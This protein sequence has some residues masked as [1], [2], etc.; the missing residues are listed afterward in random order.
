MAEVKPEIKSESPRKAGDMA[1]FE[2]DTDLQIP[3]GNRVAWL[4]KVSEDMWRAWAKMYAD[5]PE[6]Q[7]LEVGKM[8]VFHPL[9]GDAPDHTR[10]QI[11][12][13]DSR[14]EHRL[15]PKTYNLEV[16]SIG[17][18]NTVVFSEKDLPGH[19]TAPFARTNNRHL[20]MPGGI[21]K[22]DRYGNNQQPRKPGSYRTAIPKQTALAPR[23][24]NEAIANPVEDDNALEIFAQQYKSA[25]SAGNKTKYIGNQRVRHPGLGDDSF[26]FGSLTSK[27]GKSGKKKVPKEKAVRMDKDKLLDSIRNCFKEYQYWSLRALRER[28]NQPEAYIKETLEDI[29]M[30]MRAGDFVQTYKLK[31]EWERLMRQS[32]M[33][34]MPVKEEMAPVKMEGETDEDT[35]DELD[36]DGEEDF[37][38]VKMD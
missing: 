32:D 23:I 11:R 9:P 10:L 27:P 3:A 7:P 37:E 8:R 35:G 20:P 6:T 30:L 1:E 14:E 38:D 36:D 28:L 5:A 13:N 16:K 33:A 19:R 21:N 29:A 31:P 34:E 24:H 25:L 26:A 2:E 4:V 22:H 12:L 18:N 15:L 17:Y